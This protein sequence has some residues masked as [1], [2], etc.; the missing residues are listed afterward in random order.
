MI[1]ETKTGKVKGEYK[2]G[3]YLFKGIPYAMA[4]RFLAPMDYKWE[5][6][7]DCVKFKDKACQIKDNK[8]NLD[9]MSEDCLNLNIYTPS[10]SDNLP[11]LVEIHGGAFQTGSNQS[12]DPYHVIGNKKFIYVT[13][14]YRLGVLGY[15]YLGKELGEKYQSSGNNGTL[16]QLAALKWIHENIVSFGGNPNK[17]TLLG[18]S[19]GAKSIGALMSNSLSKAYFQQAILISGAYQSIR[20]E[21]TAQVITDR[22]KKNIKV[23]NSQELLTLP[24]ERLLEAQN[25]LCQGFG[26][27]C[28]FGPVADGIVIP[29]DFFDKIHSSSYWS[30]KAIVGSSKTELIF[31]KW[32]N[33]N[34][35]EEGKTIAKELFEQN[36]SIAIAEAEELSKTMNSDD[37]WVKVLSDYMYRT[38]SYRLGQILNENGS[39]V[40]QYSTELQPACHCLD[41]TLS[42]E[43]RNK[44]EMYYSQAENMQDIIRLGDKIRE[45]YLSFVI[46][47]D[48]KIKEWVPLNEQ[49]V[50]MI[51]DTPEHVEKINS[52]V[53][54]QFPEQVYR[55]ENERE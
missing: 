31:Y 10:L 34:L 19:A 40:W 37:A 11:V 47:G 43:T 14:N 42:L 55:I 13:I 6:I 45:A 54:N 8:I 35:A 50:Q 48:P 22:F 5:G 41:H 15:L 1:I 12:M 21:H 46:D 26:S 28:M 17:V 49:K 38:Y 2:Q 36:A 24:V 3:L 16:D 25:I 39:T 32:A 4:K 30:G 29:D 52:E 51:W 44:L 27:T 9:G 7:L 33:L 23:Q 20:D 18:S 53:C